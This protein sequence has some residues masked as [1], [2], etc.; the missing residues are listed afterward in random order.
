MRT[1]FCVTG[2]APRRDETR[3]N[4]GVVVGNGD[5]ASEADSAPVAACAPRRGALAF[6]DL[7]LVEYTGVTE[8]TA[9]WTAARAA[10]A[11]AAAARAVA[12]RC[13]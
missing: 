3:A 10:P 12:T 9:A 11:R 2:N 5:A 6:A 13:A 4:A 1:G 7:P 8:R